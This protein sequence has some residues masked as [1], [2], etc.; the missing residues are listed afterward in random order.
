MRHRMTTSGIA[1]A[2]RQ[3]RPQPE[4]AWPD[5]AKTQLT[6]AVAKAADHA[7]SERT[8]ALAGELY[9][10]WF[11]PAQVETPRSLLRRPLVGLYRQAHAGSSR[12]IGT[13]DWQIIDRRDAI[14]RD[15]WWRTWGPEW[16]PGVR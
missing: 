3:A 4:S 14:G 10:E 5:W 6:D 8:T 1:G 16:S 11:A 13:D 9:H 7:S 15:R 2:S 12:R